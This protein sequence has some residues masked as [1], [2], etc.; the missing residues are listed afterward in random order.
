MDQTGKVASPEGLGNIDLLPVIWVKTEDHVA[1]LPVV[2]A[3]A[4]IATAS[5]D[6]ATA[7]KLLDEALS[8]ATK[9][10]LLFFP[11]DA[12][13]ALGE[14][15]IESGKVAAGRTRLRTLEKDAEDKGFLLIARKAATAWKG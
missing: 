6:L 12:R 3:S 4:R 14:L 15:E 1:D 13:L 5:G 9:A 10:N 11:Y 2:I 7:R 8:E